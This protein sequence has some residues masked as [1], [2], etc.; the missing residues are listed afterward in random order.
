MIKVMELRKWLNR[1][2]RTL[3]ADALPF[4]VNLA[5]QFKVYARADETYQAKLK[6]LMAWQWERM[7]VAISSADRGPL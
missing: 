7:Q 2:K 5:E 1:T 4:A 6:P 3:P